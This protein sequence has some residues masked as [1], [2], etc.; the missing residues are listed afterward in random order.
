MENF[1]FVLPKVE[2]ADQGKEK[3]I[4]TYKG[5]TRELVTHDYSE[6]YKIP[7]LYENLF[8]DTLACQSPK[9]VC[10]LLEDALG[11]SNAS[12]EELVALDIGAGNGMV[13][14]EL[15]DMGV[16]TVLGVDIIEE[17][18]DA[19]HRDRP[20]VYD[21]YYV[22]DLTDL[23]QKVKKEIT[24]KK[25]NCMS[26]VA[27]LGFDDIPPEA[28]AKG[29]NLIADDGWIAFNIKDEFLLKDH[30]SG[31]SRLI[32]HMEES[33]LM[34]ICD[35]KHYQHRLCLDGT[36]LNYYAVIGK[37]QGRISDEVIAQV[38]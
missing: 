28:F 11:E 23:P 31:F 14:E 3:I 1:S 38:E 37:K 7:G 34:E 18:A 19:A 21:A 25:P 2:K 6:I 29:Y 13:G 36:P 10:G 30:S 12:P 24:R 27:A 4:V 33:G 17:A 26:I 32:D 22:E 35:R 5:K 16:D 15:V 20:G 8:Y 9:V